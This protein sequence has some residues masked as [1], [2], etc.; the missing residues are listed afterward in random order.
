MKRPVAVLGAG[1]MGSSTALH[2]ARLGVPVTLFDRQ[3]APF[4]G[5]SRWN[6]GKIHLGFLYSA[7]PTLTTARAVLPGGLDF[8][9]QVE[10]LTESSLAGATTP[11]EDLYLVHRDSVVAPGAVGRYLAAVA[12][13][14]RQHPRA[15]RYL[16]DVS[17]SRVTRLPRSELEALG[18]PRLVVAGYR[19][20]ERS[21][22]TNFVADAFVDALDGETRVELA[23]GQTATA[24]SPVDDERSDRWFVEAGDE[25]HGP[26][27]AVVNALWEGR[28]RID[29]FVGHRP[30]TAE[31]HRYRVALFV[32]TAEQLDSPSAVLAVGPFGDVKN[33]GGHSFYVSWY[34]AGLL[35]RAESVD[36]PSVSELSDRERKRI[37]SEVFGGLGTPCPW[38]TEIGRVASRVRVEGGWVY[39]QGRGPLDDPSAG[40]HRRDRL[41]ISRIGSFF[42]VDTGKYSVAPT[43]G[44]ELAKMIATAS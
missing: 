25:R 24:V 33:Y 36:P 39:S 2:L 27:H 38:V 4:R 26:F 19:V 31:Q 21:V 17:R 6:E 34:D 5:A 9:D 11:T 30:D 22:D 16:G 7:D 41:G 42:S 32:E 44:E 10:E 37:I 8:K 18:D 28:P 35:A 23:M 40:V 12:E 3:D 15:R 29:R 43:L 20:P 13:L 14:V 1:I